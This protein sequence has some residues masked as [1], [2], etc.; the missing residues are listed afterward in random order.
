MSERRRGQRPAQT[1]HPYHLAHGLLDHARYLMR[2]CDAEGATAA[3]QEA[4][5]IAGHLPC[6]PLLDRAAGIAPAKPAAQ[7]QAAALHDLEESTNPVR[8]H[9]RPQ[10]PD[11]ARPDTSR[12]IPMRGQ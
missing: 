4:R 12:M 10:R 7:D 2:T 8:G 5:A 9:C 1:E 11:Y 3:I 6:Q